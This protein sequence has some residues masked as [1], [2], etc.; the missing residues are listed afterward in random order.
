M[1]PLL[2]RLYNNV[3]KADLDPDEILVEVHQLRNEL[4]DLDEG[5]STKCST[6]IILDV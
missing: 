6:T 1:R 4:S 2:R 3:I 5:V